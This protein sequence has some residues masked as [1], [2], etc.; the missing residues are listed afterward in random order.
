[1]KRLS[2]LLLLAAGLAHATPATY[3]ID[4]NHTYPSFEADHMGISVWRGKF[5]KSSG[6]VMLDKAA[7]NGTLEVKVELDSI[8]F[9]QD[10]L[11]DWAVKPE[12]FDAKKFPEAVFKGRLAGFQNGAPTQA[13]G[14]LTLHGVTKPA[15]LQ[16][17]SFKCVPHPMLKRELCG[18]DVYTT[19][20]RDE[21]G[22]AAGKDFG[23]KMNVDLRIQ[24]EALK[25]E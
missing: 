20:Q 15:T 8:D 13:V 12:F 9:G 1:M 10:M 6:T 3:K 5:N 22:L 16:I 18:A 23:F 24:V 21:F 25:E 4:P 7:G 17:K 11:N 14:N 2:V 19:I